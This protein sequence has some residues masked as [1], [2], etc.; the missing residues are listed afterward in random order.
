MMSISN[1]LNHKVSQG[2]KWPN[3]TSC[4]RRNEKERGK[5]CFLLKHKMEGEM[6]TIKHN[7]MIQ[8]AAQN[9]QYQ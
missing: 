6:I 8:Q 3:K 4:V 7:K 9:N 5:E 1:K 2:C